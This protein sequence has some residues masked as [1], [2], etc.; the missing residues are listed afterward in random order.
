MVAEIDVILAELEEVPYLRTIPGLGWASVAGLLAH[1]GPVSLAALEDQDQRDAAGALV[2]WILGPPAKTRRRAKGP[3]KPLL[4]PEERRAHRRASVARY[5]GKTG[6][7]R[8]AARAGAGCNCGP[9]GGPRPRGA[10]G[11]HRYTCPASAN[12]GPK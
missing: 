10:R 4:T 6:A 8:H 11:R 3:P 7:K 12:F 5:V 1:V 2:G 9:D